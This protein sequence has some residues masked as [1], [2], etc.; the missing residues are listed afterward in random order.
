MVADVPATTADL[1]DVAEKVL[2][3]TFAPDIYPHLSSYDCMEVSQSLMH[4]II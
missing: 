3:L 2:Q 1:F 4:Q